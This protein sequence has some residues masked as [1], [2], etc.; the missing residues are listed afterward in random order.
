MLKLKKEFKL[1]KPKTHEKQLN[2]QTSNKKSIIINKNKKREYIEIGL[3]LFILLNS[4]RLPL[5][6]VPCLSTSSMEQ[7]V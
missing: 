3:K 5:I 4:N 2:G 6:F 7:V 1:L